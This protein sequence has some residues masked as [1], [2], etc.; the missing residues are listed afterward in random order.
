MLVH[1]KSLSLWEIAHYWHDYDPRMSSIH[2]IPLKV[3]DTLLVLLK[4]SV[5]AKFNV[6]VEKHR[7]YLLKLFRYIQQITTECFLQNLQES[8]DKKV[9]D[10]RLFNSII[11]TRN[12]LALWC[13]ENNEPLPKFWFPDNDKYPYDLNDEN[14]IE[15]AYRYEFLLLHDGPEKTDPGSEVK[16]VV[17]PSV[18]SN[19]AKAANAKHAGT[20]AIKDRFISFYLSDGGKHPDKT[21]AAKHFF[22]SLDKRE[23]LLFSTSKTATRAFLEA[24]RKHEK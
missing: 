5:N 22:D 2:N 21:A 15:D 13:I 3:R 24:L 7:A 20:N 14:L 4:T 9:F 6:Y 19:A 1:I 10:K 11:V 8:I 18:S 17:S 16:Q 12:A 23:Q